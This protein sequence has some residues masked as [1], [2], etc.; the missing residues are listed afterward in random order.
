MHYYYLFATDI[1]QISG[2][3][4]SVES[5]AQIESHHRSIIASRLKGDTIT[6]LTVP[7]HALPLRVII[8][9]QMRSGSSFTGE[10]FN[11]N[12]DFFYLFE[13][14]HYL[15]PKFYANQ[16]YENFETYIK[17]PLRDF[18]Q[19]NFQ[20]LPVTWWDEGIIANHHCKYSRSTQTLPLCYFNSKQNLWMPSTNISN[21]TNILESLCN[22]KKHFALKT[23]RITDIKHLKDLITDAS[24]DTKII[25][26]VRD[27]RGAYSSRISVCQLTWRNCLN[28]SETCVRMERNI[29][30]WLDTPSW[31]QNKYLLVRY[32]DLALEPI[33]HAEEI[34]KFLNIPMPKSVHNWIIKNT[35][36][37]EDETYSY[38][39]TRDA[40]EI[41]AKWRNTLQ[42]DKVLEVQTQCKLVMDK[43]GYRSVDNETILRNL[44]YSA[45]EPLH[46]NK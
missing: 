15:E 5:I 29:Q 1:T 21:S 33:R 34:Y 24:M 13:P 10:L 32:E 14:L 37:R 30:F 4:K 42:M 36:H 27:P 9:T 12:D 43:L 17:R 16:T 41:V 45:T 22:S 18:L 6:N 26:L 7:D 8:L 38:S 46:V 35:Q 11:N 19:C 23:I 20:D 39:H 28:I 25:H 44:D 2:A 3:Y 40:R 31:L